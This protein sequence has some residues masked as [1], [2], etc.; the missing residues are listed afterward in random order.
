LP[1]SE[2]LRRIT[3]FGVPL[4]TTSPPWSPHPDRYR[5]SNPLQALYPHHVQ[6]QLRYYLNCSYVTAFQ[7]D[8]CYHV[9]AKQSMVHLRHKA[10]LLRLSLFESINEVAVLLLLIRFM[11]NAI[12][13]NNLGLHFSRKIIDRQ[14]LLKLIVRFAFLS[15]LTKDSRKS[16]M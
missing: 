15:L 4:A 3:C 6:R 1:V 7:S 13:L 16:S 9:G 14:F 11:N 12:R 10:P 8:D 5:Q 2:L